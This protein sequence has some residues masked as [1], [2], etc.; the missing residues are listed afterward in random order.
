MITQPL[1]A[2]VAA[3]ADMPETTVP[4]FSIFIQAKKF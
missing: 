4:A 2:S 1:V 3:L